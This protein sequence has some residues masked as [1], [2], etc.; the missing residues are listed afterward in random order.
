VQQGTLQRGDAFVIGSV[1]GRVRA[2]TDDR[3]KEVKQAP[4]A[5]PVQIVGISGVPEVG[6]EFV[7][8][9]N[10]RDAKQLAEHR[11]A[12]QKRAVT[13]AENAPSADIF[14]TFG[15]VEGKELRVVVKTDV[16]G[17]MEAVRDGIANLATER[18]SVKVIHCGVGAI[19]ESD[20]MLASA[21]RAVVIGFHV[22]PEP[23]ARKAAE[24]EHVDIHT[25]DIVYELLDETKRLMTG[26][27]PPKMVEKVTG[28]AEVRE[29][30]PIRG[31]GTIA[32]CFVADGVIRRSNLM[33][34]VRNGVPVY[35]GKLDSLR[36]FK[37]D[38]REVQ[39]NFECGIHIEN[40]ND[41]KVGDRLE[42]YEIEE[43][44]DTL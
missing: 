21:S 12:E 24:R 6:E 40:Y 44:P 27:L 18:V 33:R 30:F 20:I 35:T 25:F 28:H 38:V 43:R 14:A 15:E 34:V 10:E 3:G 42:S 16:R 4:P 31:G 22:R 37:D 19:T 7:V 13:V 2:M 26:L 5:T 36:R 17:T 11:L 8:V 39:Q 41:V 29:L 23:A 1:Y 9:K 32:G